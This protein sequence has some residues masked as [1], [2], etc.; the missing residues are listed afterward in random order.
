MAG[1]SSRAS[2]TMLTARSSGTSMTSPAYP[3]IADIWLFGSGGGGTV[4]Q[5]SGGGAEAVHFQC[6][7]GPSQAISYALGAAVTSGDGNPTTVTL[8]SGRV[9]TALGGKGAVTNTPGA[10]GGQNAT[11][12][13][14]QHRRGGD[15]G[16]TS[17]N[18]NAG[19]FGGAGGTTSGS[20]GG[21]GGS[22]GFSDVADVLVNGGVGAS[23]AGHTAPGFGGGG[24]SSNASGAG[25]VVALFTRMT[26]L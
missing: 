2:T 25:Y 4:T 23:S 22:G 21:G 17:T 15:G 19:S 24:E 9:L 26:E 14:E 8:P 16:A 3:T 11:F 6:R 20:A 12:N 13:G 5:A 10:G 7:L 18:G 1:K